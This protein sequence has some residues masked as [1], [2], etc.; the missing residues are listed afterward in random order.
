MLGT[1]HMGKLSLWD[2]SGHTDFY[3][4]SMFSRIK[5]PRGDSPDGATGAEGQDGSTEDYQLKP[6]NCP[7]HC[8]VYAARP[9]SYRDLPLRWAEL[10]TVYRCAYCVSAGC[11]LRYTAE[12]CLHVVF[13]PGMSRLERSTA[14]FA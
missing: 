13:D 11:G 3:S 6:M 14:C 8:A 10:G 7:F 4:S 5:V 9:R 12:V 2:T 1:P